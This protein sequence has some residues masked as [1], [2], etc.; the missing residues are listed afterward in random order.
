[1]QGRLPRNEFD[2]IYMYQPKEMCPKGGIY[3]I[4]E[5]LQRVSEGNGEKRLIG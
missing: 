4:P 1:M 3:I 2:N 5:G